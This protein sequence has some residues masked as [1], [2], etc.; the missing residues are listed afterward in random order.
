MAW[1]EKRG[2]GAI[3]VHLVRQACLDWCT[4]VREVGEQTAIIGQVGRGALVDERKR[5]HSMVND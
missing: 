5:T 3:I 4:E 2:E 1:F